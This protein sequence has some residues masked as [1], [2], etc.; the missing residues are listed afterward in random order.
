MRIAVVSDIHGNLDALEAVVAD[1]RH[2]APDLVVH[3]GDLADAGSM[4]AET[5]DRIRDLGWSGVM[6]NTDE[7]LV[8]PEAAPAALW[9]SVR[10]MADWTRDALGAERLEWLSSLAPALRFDDFALVHASPQSC[11]RAPGLH[12]TDAEL[13]EVYGPLGRP[14]AIYGHIHVPFLR[15]TGSMIVANAGSAGMPYDGDPR[16]CYLL[17]DDGNP[18][19]RRVAYDVDTACARLLVSGLPYADWVAG[20][21]RTGVPSLP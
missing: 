4:P 10:E 1:V 6:G 2:C 9:A 13:N 3:G 11:W 5:V 18:T 12:A 20:M 7:M 17:L 8:R 21:L 14:V 19:I 15:A 16:A